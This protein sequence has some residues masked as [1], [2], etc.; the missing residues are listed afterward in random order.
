MAIGTSRSITKINSRVVLGMPPKYTNNVDY[1]GRVYKKHFGNENKGVMES[2]P[3]YPFKF[4]IGTGK[5]VFGSFN[6]TIA[7]IGKIYDTKEFTPEQKAKEA[8][9]VIKKA[10]E[11][12]KDNM[13]RGIRS[14]EFEP[15]GVVADKKGN[16]YRYY[17][18]MSAIF[19][20]M[21]LESRSDDI[22][23]LSKFRDIV[24][25]LTIL[26]TEETSLT[27]SA[28]NEVGDSFI[29]SILDKGS[30]IARELSFSMGGSTTN[31]LSGL[32]GYLK[33]EAGNG[34]VGTAVDFLESG[35]KAGMNLA[36][37][38]FG[39]DLIEIVK[40]GSQLMFP[41]VWKSS[42]FTKTISISIKL[43]SPYGTKE[44]LDK[45]VFVPLSYILGFALP[46][47]STPTTYKY[48]FLVQVDSPGAAS[49]RMGIVSGITIKKG[50][51][52]DIWSSQGLFR[53]VD[54][55]LDITDLYGVL[56]VPQ[57]FE[58]LANAVET[59]DYF[60]NLSGG[61]LISHESMVRAILDNA[62]TSIKDVTRFNQIIQRVSNEKKAAEQTMKELFEK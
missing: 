38:L 35:A 22:V 14:F 10:R 15:D 42:S 12:Q 3:L 43:Y 8:E 46:I 23:L 1:N 57:S 7:A 45:F 51:R 28:S 47:Q 49:V 59:R 50:G 56:T 30:E 4:T 32:S 6:K 5:P 53:G 26:G 44:A 37:D 24:P 55:T 18:V 9:A 52:Y 34:L 31:F 58:V 25:S 21:T 54:V 13:S 19:A 17:E 41:K 33:A 39:E 11:E 61:D 2:T 29:K 36:K 48:P 40:D 62:G 60:R 27:D 16:K 20:S